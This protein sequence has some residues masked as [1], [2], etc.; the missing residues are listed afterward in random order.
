MEK[1]KGLKETFGEENY[2]KIEFVQADISDAKQMVAAM[3]GV[4]HMLHVASPVPNSSVKVN[5]SQMV[6]EVTA[7]M[8]TILDC[9]L[10]NKLKKLIVTS[11]CVTMTEGRPKGANNPNYSEVDYSYDQPNL[12]VDWYI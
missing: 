6:E 4:T 7:G 1:A 3:E 12:K 10:K 2:N 9:A 11:S 5:E 8:K